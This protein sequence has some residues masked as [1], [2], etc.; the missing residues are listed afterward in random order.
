ME[1]R[2]SSKRF[3]LERDTDLSGTSGTGIVAYGVEFPD[4]TCAMRW[5]TRVASTALYNSIADLTHIH[6]H[7]GATRV[8]FDD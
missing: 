4:G 1:R 8:V 5:N 7:E 2:E 6:S 3:H